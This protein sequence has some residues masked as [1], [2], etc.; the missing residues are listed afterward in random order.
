MVLN[1]ARLARESSAIMSTCNFT[2]RNSETCKCLFYSSEKT[3]CSSA[4]VSR[5]ATTDSLHF[6]LSLTGNSNLFKSLYHACESAAEDPDIY[7]WTQPQNFN[8]YV[9]SKV[10][11]ILYISLKPWG[12]PIRINRFINQ[13]CI[14]RLYVGCFRAIKLKLCR[15]GILFSRSR[16]TAML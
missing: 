10:R 2:C 8:F 13:N 14:K 11:A 6:G 15:G 9:E 3:S 7:E 12:T 16:F 4:L 1:C 5:Q